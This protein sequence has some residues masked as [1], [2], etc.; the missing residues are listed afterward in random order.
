MIGSL[1]KAAV[2]VI[3]V[4][5]SIAADVVTLGGVL[6]DKKTTHTGDALGRLVDNVADATTPDDT[7][8]GTGC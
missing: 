7:G 5:V 4:P 3:D 1:L 8:G 2:S 6:V